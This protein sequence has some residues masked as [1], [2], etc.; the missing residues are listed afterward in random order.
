MEEQYTSFFIDD[1][2]Y[3]T[4][5]TEKFK[6]RKKWVS[7]DKQ[8]VISY[9]PGTIDKIY[10][11]PNQKVKQGEKLLILEA[12]KM[13]NTIIAPCDGKIKYINVQIGDKIPKNELL[14]VLE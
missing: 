9:I 14:I 13:K 10:V 8:K 5:L 4:L 12:M 11:K 7:I 3:I 1:T 2:E 6:R